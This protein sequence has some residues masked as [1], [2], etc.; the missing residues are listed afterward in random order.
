EGA[1]KSLSATASTYELTSFTG[2]RTVNI[3]RSGPSIAFSGSAY[4]RRAS[5][6][7]GRYDLR[8]TATDG[9][10][11]SAATRRS[12]ATRIKAVLNGQSTILD[13]TQACPTDS[14]QMVRDVPIDAAPLKPGANH[15]EVTAY[16]AAGNPS[17]PQRFDFTV[18]CCA[19]SALDWILD[20]TPNQDVVFGDV[21]GDGAADLVTRDQTSG[22]VTVRPSDGEDSF[23]QATAWGTWPVDRS[24]ALADYDGDGLDDLMGYVPATG[25]LSTSA[26]QGDSFQAPISIGIGPTGRRVLFA[27]LDLTDTADVLL[28]DP[29]TGALSSMVR[30][31]ETLEGPVDEGTLPPN[32]VLRVAD[33]DRDGS[34]DIVAIPTQ[35]GGDVSV[36]LLREDGLT[37][38]QSWGSVPA[39]I[40]ADLADGDGDGRADLLV[41]RAGERAVDIRPSTGTSFGEPQAY[42]EIDADHRLASA[43]VSGDLTDDLLGVAADGSAVSVAV[44]FAERLVEAAGVYQPDP[45]LAYDDGTDTDTEPGSG[46]SQFGALQQ[47]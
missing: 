35:A 25:A 9:S 38:A 10:T 46:P 43:D 3:D 47:V 36:R 17:P 5:M 41:R 30:A 42:G 33:V 7:R 39:S 1:G 19:G 11:S 20:L 12:G 2:S 34:G 40:E 13:E 28:Y 15:V 22:Q 6:P 26:S 45:T 16:D 21:N 31:G 18:S 14:C 27:D 8:V 37:A 23:G 29:A 32:H 24:I 44:S 4:D